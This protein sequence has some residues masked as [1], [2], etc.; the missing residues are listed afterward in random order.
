[1]A[2]PFLSFPHQKLAKKYT[3][4]YIHGMHTPSHYSYLEPAVRTL[5]P[6]VCNRIADFVYEW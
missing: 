2:T 6:G 5:T 4:S 1:M 3:S